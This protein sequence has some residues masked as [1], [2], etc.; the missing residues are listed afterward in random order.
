MRAKDRE[1]FAVET[2]NLDFKEA[3]FP[4]VRGEIGQM[5]RS[6]TFKWLMSQEGWDTLRNVTLNLQLQVIL[7]QEE[8]EGS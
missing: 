8:R 2:R 5:S 7:L 3:D 6:E 4:K 1:S